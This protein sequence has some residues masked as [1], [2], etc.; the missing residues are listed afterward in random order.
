MPDSHETAPSD[1]DP[2][3]LDMSEGNAHEDS[4]A[5]IKR[6][7]QQR[8]E[9]LLQHPQ[10]LRADKTHA[11]TLLPTGFVELDRLLRGGWPAAAL[12]EVFVERYGGGEISL[13]LPALR[14]RALSAGLIVWVSPPYTPYAPALTLA[15]LDL[16]RMLV[17]GATDNQDALWSIEQAAKS[18]VSVAVL[19][20]AAA[21]SDHA[22]RRLQLAAE[23]HGCWV[24]LF[25]PVRFVRGR[26]VA[27]LR[28]RVSPQ[29]GNGLQVRVLKNR[30]AS[31]GCVTVLL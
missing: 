13:L 31:P 7:K 21:V 6:D 4:A 17:V 18:G 14:Q 19:G 24:L 3:E 9:Q 23:Q 27:A 15:G 10:I 28:L 29:S 26:S 8:L 22:L 16:S 2:S 1:V 25:R 11:Q 5:T 20:W 12:T 30:I